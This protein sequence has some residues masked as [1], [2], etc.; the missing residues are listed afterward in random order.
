MKSAIEEI[1]NKLPEVTWDRWAG[2][3]NLMGVFGWLSRDDGRFDF[4]HLCIA[5]GKVFGF[6]TSSAKYSDEFAGRL[7][8]GDQHCPCKRVEDTFAVQCVRL[9]YPGD[10]TE[11]PEYQK[12]LEEMAK[13]CHCRSSECPCDG[14]LAG[15]MCDNIQDNP[16]DSEAD[17]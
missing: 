1:L 11:S 14:I 6:S 5:E 17:E 15:G 2:E 9:E 12:H 7:G 3:L 8:I 10:F 4:V 13:L 16:R